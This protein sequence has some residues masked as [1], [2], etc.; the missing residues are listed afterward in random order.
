MLAIPT[1]LH[2]ACTTPSDCP[3]GGTNYQCNANQ[4]ECPGHLVEDV[5]KCVGMLPVK[6]KSFTYK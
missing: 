4:C 1:S 3:D 2:S 6:K 5:E